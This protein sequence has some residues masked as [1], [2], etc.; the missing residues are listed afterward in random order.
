MIRRP[1]TPPRSSTLLPYTPLFRSRL[2][3]GGFMVRVEQHDLEL[4]ALQRP[5]LGPLGGQP[6]AEL[7]LVGEV[8]Q[9]EVALEPPVGRDELQQ[10]GPPVDRDRKSTRL[11]SSH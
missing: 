5:A 6:G 11:N 10:L 8:H 3:D 7:D 2:R 1:P 4:R 9:A